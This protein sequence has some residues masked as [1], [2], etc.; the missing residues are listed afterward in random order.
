MCVVLRLGVASRQQKAV[1]LN[2][3]AALGNKRSENEVKLRVLYSASLIC[4]GGGGSIGAPPFMGL[5]L[6]VCMRQ[7]VGV[8]ARV[9]LPAH[10][11]SAQLRFL[12]PLVPPL[13]VFFSSQSWQNFFGLFLFAL[14]ETN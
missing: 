3:C 8:Q 2:V 7:M 12:E 1:C 4:C 5:S 13:G 9:T 11:F 14:D 6:C 10:Q